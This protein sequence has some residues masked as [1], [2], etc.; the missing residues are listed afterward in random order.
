MGVKGLKNLVQEAL[1]C[2]FFKDNKLHLPY[3]LMKL[4][5]A[6]F[7]VLINIKLHSKIFCFGLVSLII[8]NNV[9]ITFQVPYPWFQFAGWPG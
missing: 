5:C 2:K 6:L 9:Y 1:S 7:L 8:S 3:G 4:C